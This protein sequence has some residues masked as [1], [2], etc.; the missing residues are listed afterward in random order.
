VLDGDVERE[1]RLV[2]AVRRIKQ[3]TGTELVD[4]PVNEV[5]GLEEALTRLGPEADRLLAEG[6]AMT[7]DEAVRYALHELEPVGRHPGVVYPRAAADD[8]SR[9]D[10]RDSLRS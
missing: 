7:D 5:P 8:G 9:T 3:L 2:G 4:H 10:L 6:A 1:V